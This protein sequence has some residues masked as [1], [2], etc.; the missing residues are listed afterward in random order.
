VGIELRPGLTAGRKNAGLAGEMVDDSRLEIRGR[1]GADGSG[2]SP[3]REGI[4][5]GRE[6]IDANA[7]AVGNWPW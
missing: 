2:P 6:S 4:G 3:G 7:E 1:P 5:L